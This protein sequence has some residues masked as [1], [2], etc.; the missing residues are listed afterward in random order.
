MTLTVMKHRIA[1]AS[2]RFKGEIAASFYLLTIL[3]GVVVFFAGG[4]LGLVLDIIAAAFYL[5]VTV[6]FYFLTRRA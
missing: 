2:P 6:V 4:K 5:G 3:A 1:E